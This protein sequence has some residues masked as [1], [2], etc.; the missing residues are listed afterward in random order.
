MQRLFQ[1]ILPAII[2]VCAIVAIHFMADLLAWDKAAL[3]LQPGSWV[4]IHGV[5]TMVLV[6]ADAAHLWSNTLGLLLLL[7]LLFVRYRPVAW[8]VLSLSWVLTGFFVFFLAKENTQHIGASGFL[9]ALLI[10]LIVA[11]LLAANR[12]LRMLSFVLIMYY[13]SM[14]W[15]VFPLQR[16]VSWEGHLSGAITGFI[17]AILLRGYYLKYTRDVKPPWFHENE[18]KEDPY[19]AFDNRK[20]P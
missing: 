11:G 4:H 9:Y 17:L 16:H 14:V 13:G 7:S 1:N 19:S 6:H 15:G 3:S 18:S 10:F 20:K 5:V 8:L 2:I 12:S